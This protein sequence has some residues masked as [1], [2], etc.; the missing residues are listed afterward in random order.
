MECTSSV[1]TVPRFGLIAEAR[2][3][4]NGTCPEP[5]WDEQRQTLIPPAVA[6]P[7]LLFLRSG[8]ASILRCPANNWTTIRVIPSLSSGGR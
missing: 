6:E 5:L 1:G 2:V 7:E 4:E 8:E 3:Q